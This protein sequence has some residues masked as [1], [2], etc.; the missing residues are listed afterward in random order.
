MLGQGL[1]GGVPADPDQEAVAHLRMAELVPLHRGRDLHEGHVARFAPVPGVEGPVQVHEE[2]EEGVVGPRLAGEVESIVGVG[3]VLQGEGRVE[4]GGQAVEEDG[5][6]HLLGEVLGLDA[7]RLL[8][9]G[10]G[11]GQVGAG[12]HEP[13]EALVP[14]PLPFVG[15]HLQ[16]EASVFVGE[17]VPL[18]EAVAPGPIAVG[19]GRERVA[20]GVRLAPER[21]VLGPHPLGRR[22]LPVRRAPARRDRLV[23]ALATEKTLGVQIALSL[24]ERRR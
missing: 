15:E 22:R 2:V 7:L 24:D 19:K 4:A 13:P 21:P 20:L 5:V 16:E 23:A 6:L 1:S 9:G 11:F 17:R 12:G 8:G 3:D 10:Q 14:R 18:V